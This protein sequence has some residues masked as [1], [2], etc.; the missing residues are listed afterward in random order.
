MARSKDSLGR[1]LD[2]LPDA[3]RVL[4]KNRDQIVEAFAALRRVAT[5][6]SHVLS[7]IKGDFAEDLKGLYSV[8]KAL[9]DSRKDFVT[10]L[11]L[12]LTFPFPTSASSRRCAATTSTCSPPST[13][14][15]DGSAKRFSRHRM[16]S[17]RT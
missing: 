17:I 1:T 14:P 15:C 7:Q 11:Q 13:S 12:L 5:V 3:L 8:T 4:N 6:A 10:S 9:A 2:T 16:H